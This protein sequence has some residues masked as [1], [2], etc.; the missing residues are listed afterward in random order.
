VLWGD[1]QKYSYEKM[2]R[3]VCG[4]RLPT[5]GGTRK[6]RRTSGGKEE[7]IPSKPHEVKEYHRGRKEKMVFNCRNMSTVK[8]K[9]EGG[10]WS[11]IR[12]DSKANFVGGGHGFGLLNN[13][14]WVL[15]PIGAEKSVTKEENGAAQWWACET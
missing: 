10:F 8:K 9:G 3:K 11:D 14:D 7:K 2:G 13:N 6:I 12:G 5:G 4:A 1:L 15:L